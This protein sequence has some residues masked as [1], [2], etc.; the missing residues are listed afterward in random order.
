[1]ADGVNW[2]LIGTTLGTVTNFQNPTG[3]YAG[4]T[5][6]YRVRACASGRI[7]DPSAQV[8]ATTITQAPT[9]LVAT[10]ASPGQ[11]NLT[12]NDVFGETGFLIERSQDA[13][14]WTTVGSIRAGVTSF[15]DSGLLVGTRYIYRVR[16]SNSGG[17]SAASNLASAIA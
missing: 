4:H 11:I 1:S 7:S 3:L 16:A 5:Y 14:N 9:A 12:W 15:Q 2:A 10:T 8:S 17:I 6:F 13:I